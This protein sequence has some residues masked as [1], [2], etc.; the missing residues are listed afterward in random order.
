M[1]DRGHYYVTNT[2]WG[3]TSKPIG[4]FEAT[5]TSLGNSRP[6][7]NFFDVLPAYGM[8]SV[9]RDVTATACD[10]GYRLTFKSNRVFRSKK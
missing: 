2:S 6:K 5:D 10:H 4:L 1:G 9:L 7:K 8:Y 3:V